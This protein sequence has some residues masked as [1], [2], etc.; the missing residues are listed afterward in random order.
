[1]VTALPD[2]CIQIIILANCLPLHF[3][4]PSHFQ[5]SWNFIQYIFFFYNNT[6]IY[7]A[8]I[9]LKQLYAYSVACTRNIIMK[10]ELHYDDDCELLLLN[11]HSWIFFIYQQLLRKISINRLHQLNYNDEKCLSLWFYIACDAQNTLREL[12]SGHVMLISNF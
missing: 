12:S 11:R 5:W 8:Y 10:M 1:M 6:V 4:V 2:F 3:G 7:A 9:M